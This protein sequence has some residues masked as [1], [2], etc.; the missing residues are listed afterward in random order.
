MAVAALPVGP[1]AADEALVNATGSPDADK[2]YPLPADFDGP[3]VVYGGLIEPGRVDYYAFTVAAGTPLNMFVAVPDVRTCADFLPAFALV[4][5]G[6]PAARAATPVTAPPPPPAGLT[7]PGGSGA[8]VVAGDDLGTYFEQASGTTFRVGPQLGFALTG[9][10]YL[11]AVYD[12]TGGTGTYAL[13]WGGDFVP[14]AAGG[15]AAQLTPWQ[16]CTPPSAT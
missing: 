15:T 12:P 8:M 11:V 1:V 6:L 7:G 16:R 9:G 3:G 2:P 14:A 4:G 13:V 10:Q 5:P